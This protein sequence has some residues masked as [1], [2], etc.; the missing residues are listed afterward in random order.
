[1][2]LPFENLMH[3]SILHDVAELRDPNRTSFDLKGEADT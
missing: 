1:M 2:L 3:V